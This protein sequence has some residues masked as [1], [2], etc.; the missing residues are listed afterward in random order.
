MNHL[1]TRLYFTFVFI[2]ILCL[3]LLFLLPGVFF[4]PQSLPWPTPACLSSHN[5]LGSL[6]APVVHA[7]HTFLLLESRKHFLLTSGVQ[8]S[9]VS[10]NAMLHGKPPANICGILNTFLKHLYYIVL[11]YTLEYFNPLP[12]FPLETMLHM[13]LSFVKNITKYTTKD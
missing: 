6:P 1:N 11:S 3:C 10:D 12:E 2:P 5:C 13:I 8:V 4:P 9:L 7:E